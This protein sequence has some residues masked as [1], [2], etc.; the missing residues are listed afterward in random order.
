MYANKTETIQDRREM[1]RVKVKSLAEE[2]RII[3]REE[4]RTHGALREELHFHRQW[5]LRIA[6]RH[7]GIAYGLTRGLTL[8]QMEPISY[9]KLN[10]DSI[11][12]MMKSYGP[13]DYKTVV[14]VAQASEKVSVR[15]SKS[16]CPKE[17]MASA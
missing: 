1:L 15:L 9:T 8:Q 7:A 16:E 11:A 6:A 2:A 3:R 13:K 10:W 12:K 5:P 14:D 4:Q 17:T